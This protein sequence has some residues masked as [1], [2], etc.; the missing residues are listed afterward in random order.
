MLPPPIMFTTLVR[1]VTIFFT[2]GRKVDPQSR[3]VVH[4]KDAGELRHMI[5]EAA[6]FVA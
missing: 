2:Y 4:T 1:R 3:L 6:L 5:H